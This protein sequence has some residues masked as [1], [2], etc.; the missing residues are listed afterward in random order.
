MLRR[1]GR[2]LVVLTV[3]AAALALAACGSDDYA[4]DPR[5]PVP[6]EIAVLINN[7]QVIVSPGDFGAGLVSFSVANLSDNDASL[8]IDGPTADE[9]DSIPPG[10]NT[11]LKMETETGDYTATANG[12]FAA[13][14]VFAVGPER[15]SAQNELLL[16]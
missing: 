1:T 9:S 4:N 12:T 6:A 13:P 7:R 11:T 15:P 2:A 14:L 8:E 3:A 16:P 10:G 5:P